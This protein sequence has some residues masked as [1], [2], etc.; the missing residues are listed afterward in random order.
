AREFGRLIREGAFD[1]PEPMVAEDEANP[2]PP[3]HGP[4]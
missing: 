4:K 1:Y 2:V 3:L